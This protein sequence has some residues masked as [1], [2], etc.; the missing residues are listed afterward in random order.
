MV[1]LRPKTHT[2][3]GGLT[4]ARCLNTTPR[5]GISSQG[6]LIPLLALVSQSKPF[7]LPEQSAF[8]TIRILSLKGKRRYPSP[9]LKARLSPLL[10]K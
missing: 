4:A 6:F 5:S 10:M 8:P 9:C 2:A 1:G 3:Y 7:P